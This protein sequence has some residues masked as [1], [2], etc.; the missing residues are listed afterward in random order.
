MALSAG[1]FYSQLVGVDK[2]PAPQPPSK[3]SCEQGAEWCD[4][5][6]ASVPESERQS[7][8][9]SSV[10]VLNLAQP[11]ARHHGIPPS[12]IGY[13]MM[14]RAMGWNEDEGL[15]KGGTGPLE[16]VA[17]ELRIRDRRGVGAGRRRRAVTH[18]AR[19]V[20]AA[21]G[22]APAAAPRATRGQRR[23]RLR[24]LRQLEAD[25]A[26]E[27]ARQFSDPSTQ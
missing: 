16:P 11:T 24:R 18:S 13:R 3:D 10:H 1:D 15:G 2:A 22:V 27:V 12:N 4:V 9:N 8:P 7:H 23:A 25:Y 21:A 20:D 17:T 5:C 26:R 19:E 14:V 6:G